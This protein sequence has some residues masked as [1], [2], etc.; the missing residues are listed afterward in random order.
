MDELLGT[1]GS[2]GALV[3]LRVTVRGDS[4]SLVSAF[5]FSLAVRL[6]KYVEGFMTGDFDTVRAM[7]PDDVKLD[8]VA[9]QHKQGQA[10]SRNTTL[11]TQ[12]PNSDIT[13]RA[14]SMVGPRCPCMIANS[15]SRRLPILLPWISIPIAWSRSMTSCLRD[16]RWTAS[17][18]HYSIPHRQK[19]LLKRSCQDNVIRGNGLVPSFLRCDA[20]VRFRIG[21]S[22]FGLTAPIE[23][24]MHY[25][26]NLEPIPSMLPSWDERG[27]GTPP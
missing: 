25:Q 24:E 5:L 4:L 11:P 13:R 21:L 20:H 26:L 17:T 1:E 10:R 12:P 16:M 6:I 7:L 14:W 19:T 9:K 27:C 2:T 18:C 3:A 22:H 23:E 15:H 8:L